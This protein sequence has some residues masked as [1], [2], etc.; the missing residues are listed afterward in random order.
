M[1]KPVEKARPMQLISSLGPRQLKTCV[2]VESGIT[3]LSPWKAAIVEG[4]DC[5][6]NRRSRGG[7]AAAEYGSKLTTKERRFGFHRVSAIRTANA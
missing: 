2:Y 7:P 1:V 5:C 4:Q 6:E 3:A